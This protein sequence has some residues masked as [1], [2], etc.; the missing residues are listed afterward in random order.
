MRGQNDEII[1]EKKFADLES[2]LQY[3]Y[4]HDEASEVVTRD[5]NGYICT[6]YSSRI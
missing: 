2:A 3:Y 4:D 1:A 5:R 6:T